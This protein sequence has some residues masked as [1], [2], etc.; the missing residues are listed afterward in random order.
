MVEPRHFFC[1][2]PRFPAG[3]RN[4]IC[5]RS[6]EHVWARLPSSAAQP[7]DPACALTRSAPV[8]PGPAV[9]R[10]RWH[11]TGSVPSGHAF[12]APNASRDTSRVR[13]SRAGYGLCFRVLLGPFCHSDGGPKSGQQSPSPAARRPGGVVILEPLWERP[14]GT[15]THSRRT[16][17][18]L[19]H[20]R[21]ARQGLVRVSESNTKYGGGEGDNRGRC[22]A[23][24]R[25]NYR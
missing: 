24:D 16:G 14:A 12:N 21:H 9:A 8:W 20:V 3:C 6:S 23:C 10:S 18:K 11:P 5:S 17:W 4:V 7:V 22:R 15:Q 25:A 13:F 2:V 19:G 1:P